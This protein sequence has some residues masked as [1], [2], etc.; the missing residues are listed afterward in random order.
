MTIAGGP[1]AKV[2]MYR[3]FAEFFDR[4]NKYD[5]AY[6]YIRKVIEISDSLYSA[7]RLGQFQSLEFAEQ[8]K[9]QELEKE[10]ID[11]KNRI[12]TYSLIGGLSIFTLIAVMLYRN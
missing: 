12:K 6:R 10:R 5:S 3:T 4:V 1:S 7:S 9:V 2:L 8:L 11:T